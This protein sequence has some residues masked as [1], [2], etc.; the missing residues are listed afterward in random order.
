MNSNKNIKT[1]LATDCGSTTT[2][3]I[4]IEYIDSEES[5][6]Y[7]VYEVLSE[8]EILIDNGIIDSSTTV[9]WNPELFTPRNGVTYD[10]TFYVRENWNS[11]EL[12]LLG[13]NYQLIVTY[14]N[15]ENI[16][17]NKVQVGNFFLYFNE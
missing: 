3:A 9:L 17:F 8:I 13:K 14:E 2:K 5:A 16:L 4:L 10:S 12:E 6:I 1:I 11:D 15:F 7:L